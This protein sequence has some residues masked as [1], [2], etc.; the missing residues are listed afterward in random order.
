MAA[1]R[2]YLDTCIVSGLAKGDLSQENEAALLQILEARKL[3]HVELVTSELTRTEIAAVPEEYRA[4]H[5][6]IY[7]LLT[8]VPLVATTYKIPPFKPAPMF[9]RPHPLYLALRQLLPDETDADHVYQAAQNGVA[10]LI[11][12]DKRTMLTYAKEV[13]DL[14]HVTLSSPVD[15]AKSVLGK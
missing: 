8:D 1:R 13:L 4:K 7:A 11:A 10:H 3:G 9:R 2:A 14:S 5:S 15:F 12:V 6:I